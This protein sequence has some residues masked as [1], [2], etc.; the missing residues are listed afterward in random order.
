MFET[1]EIDSYEGD[2]DIIKKKR[3]P[4][5]NEAKMHRDYQFQVGLEFKSIAIF[6]DAIKEHTLLNGRDIRIKTLKRRHTCGRDP[7]GRLASGSQRK[8][9]ITL[10]G[11]DMMLGTMIPCIHDKYMANISITKAY[12]AR[13]K[14]KQEV[15]GNYCT[16]NLRPDLG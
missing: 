2:Y 7:I 8:F 10:V 5:Y 9:P 13:R 1:K 4:K 12:W 16:D 15:H 3:Y 6:R 11:E 14:A